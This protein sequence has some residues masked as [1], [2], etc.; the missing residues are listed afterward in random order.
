MPTKTPS[1]L[2]PPCQWAYAFSPHVMERQG[3]P[4]WSPL[5]LAWGAP[6][7][8]PGPPDESGACDRTVFKCLIIPSR[9]AAFLVL[10]HVTDSNMPLTVI[11]NLLYNA[12]LTISPSLNHS[13][14]GKGRWLGRRGVLEWENKWGICS[15]EVSGLEQEVAKIRWFSL[16]YHS[17]KGF[18]KCFCESIR[19]VEGKFCSPSPSLSDSKF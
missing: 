15:S 1:S 6:G 17:Q 11:H 10:L 8:C 18:Y 4:T 9:L 3:R 2:Q 14:W 16:W 13:V 12:N 19:Q 7:T 5:L